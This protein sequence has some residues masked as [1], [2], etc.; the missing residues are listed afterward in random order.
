M[1]ESIRTLDDIPSTDAVLVTRGDR[2]AAR[3]RRLLMREARA[4]AKAC[5]AQAQQEAELIRADSFREGYSQGVLQAAGDLSKL[6]LQSRALAA[7]LQ[8]EL[9]ETARKLLGDWLMDEQ[10]LNALLQRWQEQTGRGQGPLE[11]ILPL[12]CKPRKAALKSALKDL[13]RETVDIRFHAQERYLFRLDDQVLELDIDATRER[14]SPR[15]VAQL[16]QLPDTARQL[17][18]A[19]RRLLIDW[20]SR[21]NEQAGDL[22]HL[23]EA[24]G[25]DEH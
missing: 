12:R 22:N 23:P 18:E 4:R 10:L 11:I 9:L 2:V 25:R 16:K 20:T 14:L 6:L 8:A 15:L 24:D 5:V 7:T 13:R 19:S 3:H 21:L 1:L 17:D